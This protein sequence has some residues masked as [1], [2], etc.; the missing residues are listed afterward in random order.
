MDKPAVSSAIVE[1]HNSVRN[2]VGVPPLAWSDELAQVAQ[3]WAERLVG[4][5]AFEHSRTGKYG[6]NIFEVSGTGWTS[7]AQ[8]VVGNWA[9]E[10]GNYQYPTNTCTG[11][12]GHYT[13]LVWK[14]TKEVGCG[15]ARDNNREVWVCNYAPYGNIIGEKPY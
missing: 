5:G 15:V 1:A 13:Q 7:N 10:S 6:E 2:K 12:C 9:A 8:E 11:V 14:D 4:S 3:N